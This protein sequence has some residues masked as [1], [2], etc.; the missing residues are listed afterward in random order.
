[1]L[2][3]YADRKRAKV[4]LLFLIRRAR[5]FFIGEL[6]ALVGTN[7]LPAELQISNMLD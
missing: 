5:L 3:E 1:V 7:K 2:C 4:N 6:K